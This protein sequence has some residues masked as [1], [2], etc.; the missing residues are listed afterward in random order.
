MTADELAVIL[1]ILQPRVMGGFLQKIREVAPHRI[2][3]GFH[4]GG[5]G[6]TQILVDVT[7]T[8]PRVQP[9]ERRFQAPKSA[10]PFSLALRKLLLG[11]R[12]DGLRQEPGDRIVHL[13]FLKK[14]DER[15]VP[16]DLVIEVIPRRAGLFVLDDEACI[17]LASSARDDRRGRLVRG[18]TWSPPPPPPST[19]DLPAPFLEFP[20]WTEETLLHRL[21]EKLEEAD[22]EDDVDMKGLSKSLTKAIK[23]QF[24]R[25]SKIEA[26]VRRLDSAKDAYRE[27]EALKSALGDI[28]KGATTA[29]VRDWSVDPPAWI[30]VDLDP[31]LSPIENVERIFKEAKKRE[32]GLALAEKRLE[33]QRLRLQ[34]L[35][36]LEELLGDE[37]PEAKELLLEE[38][39]TLGIEVPRARTPAEKKSRPEPRLPYKTYHSEDGTPIWVGRSSRD[40]D[41]LTFRHAK[42]NHW[43][44]HAEDY[45][46]SHVVV[47]IADPLPPEVLVDAATLA[48]GYSKAPK[49]GKQG[50]SYTRRKHVT[51]FKGAKPG[52]VLLQERKTILI[53]IDA[54]RWKRLTHRSL[55]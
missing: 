52:Q 41:V 13:Q 37:S 11:A 44:L 49:G 30:D 39:R 4:R 22:S 42:G 53:R 19:E 23:R 40:N 1:R 51:K 25:I 8:A 6:A 55:P 43:W 5:V 3:L 31:K 20:G 34:H 18:G 33:E 47:P 29:R 24:K 2:I 32:R 26:D 35:Q 45:P 27:G 21:D 46:G 54:D 12:L 10:S 28:E 16:R 7:P 36:S 38:T 9:T 14:E 17:L 48:L 50:V 15:L